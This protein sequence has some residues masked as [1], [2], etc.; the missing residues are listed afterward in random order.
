[1]TVR[2]I[3]VI[4]PSS[5]GDVIQT[6][7]AVRFLK[8]SFREA[9]LRWIVNPEWAPLLVGN[10]DLVEVIPFPRARFRGPLGFARFL[11]WSRP[12]AN[13]RPDLTLDFQGLLRSA[14]IGRATRP[15]RFLGLRDA[16]EGAAL[17]YD[18]AVNTH[19]IPHAVDRYLALARFAGAQTT[20]PAEFPLP[21]GNAL[22]NFP[23]PD[24]YMVL[25]PFARGDRKS[26]V[27]DEISR[28]VQALA[29]L[30]VAVVG[31]SGRPLPLPPNGWS[32]LNR[33]TLLE[34]IWLLRR[35]TFTV[36]VDSGPM[37]LAAA[38]TDALLSIHFWSDPR[39]VGPYRNGAWVWKEGRFQTV[40]EARQSTFAQ[41]KQSRPSMDAL[42]G[43]MHDRWLQASRP[44]V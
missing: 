36:S 10:S 12:L 1:M 30:P 16:R 19:G 41:G 31:V 13:L 35:A 5:M 34:L 33:T 18:G 3:A 21:T 7:P 38:L 44:A 25:H 42:A 22:P 15:R 28:L 27:P 23:L 32:L 14:W 39:K 37:H 43:F 20:G 40:N 24:R 6:L 9:N 8:Q 11:A 17:F 4:K 29:P 26:L 2:E